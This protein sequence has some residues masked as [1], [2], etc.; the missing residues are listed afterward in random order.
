MLTVVLGVVYDVPEAFN[1]SLP[2]WAAVNGPSPDDTILPVANSAGTCASD[3]GIITKEKSINGNIE[4]M[5]KY[6]AFD[7][8]MFLFLILLIFVVFWFQ[9]E[10]LKSNLVPTRTFQV[11]LI[12]TVHI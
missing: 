6:M 4:N 5:R 2:D 9:V 12:L 3:C 11:S 8:F 10:I 7:I 1:K